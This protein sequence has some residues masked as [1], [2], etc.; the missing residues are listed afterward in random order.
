MIRKFMSLFLSI[1]IGLGLSAC[2]DSSSSSSA[3]VNAA[4][5]PAD[6][7]NVHIGSS[8]SV[9]LSFSSQNNAQNLIFNPILPKG[10]SSSSPLPLT[11][12]NVPQQNQSGCSITLTYAPTEAT[13]NGLLNLSYSYGNTNSRSTGTVQIPYSTKLFAYVSNFSNNTVSQCVV[14]ADGS[15][16]GCASSGGE[17]SGN[18][19]LYKIAIA[20]INNT[21][22][23]YVTNVN[24][25][26]VSK[27][28][29]NSD[30]SF[31]NCAAVGNQFNSA[32]GIAI[33][34]INNTPYAYVTNTTDNNGYS[35][36]KCPLDA[37]GNFSSCSVISENDFNVPTGIAIANF[38]GAS[39]AYITN[40]NNS[41]VSQCTIDSNGNFSSCTLTGN[42]F[43]QPI[44][45]A[46][47]TVNN[48]PYAY[49]TNVNG[50]FISQCPVNADGS[51]SSCTSM[52][53]DVSPTFLNIAFMTIN[54]AVHSYITT[55]GVDSLA[56]IKNYEKQ[57]RG[58]PHAMKITKPTDINNLGYCNVNS[59]GTFSNCIATGDGFSNPYDIAF[60]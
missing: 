27:C 33:A 24:N 23:A 26:T 16:S 59:D 15:F 51:F 38:M 17:F 45:I 22:Y 14:N 31:S 37:S 32:F 18:Y 41:T 53:M 6:A 44:G 36:D 39:Y 1:I 12:A 9:T 8:T 20:T 7:N 48:T 46:I 5:S 34:T 4:V 29:I 52:P 47:E 19:G 3:T 21:P 35:I 11:C 40:L 10:W 60:Y 25:S 13:T 28:N 49:V 54:G 55:L 2:Q 50:N 42:D 56:L 30:G 57:N 58:G 43:S